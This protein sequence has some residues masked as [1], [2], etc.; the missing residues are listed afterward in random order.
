MQR[1][2]HDDVAFDE[3]AGAAHVGHG[4]A[5]AQRACPLAHVI[6]RPE[7]EIEE[8]LFLSDLTLVRH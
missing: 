8:H 7:G 4:G 3:V 1:R 2:A 5:V 6:E